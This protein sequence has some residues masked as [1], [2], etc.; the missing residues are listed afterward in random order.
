MRRHY[1]A[2]ADCVRA[3]LFHKH[4]KILSG[5]HQGFAQTDRE[6]CAARSPRRQTGGPWPGSA[7]AVAAYGR[8]HPSCHWPRLCAHGAPR[9]A[10]QYRRAPARQASQYHCSPSSPSCAQSAYRQMPHRAGR[11]PG[12]AWIKLPTHWFCQCHWPRA[13]PWRA[14][15]N[16]ASDFHAS[17]NGSAA[18]LQ[19]EAPRH[20]P[21]P[22]N[23]VVVRDWRKPP[24]LHPHRHENVKRLRVFIIAHQSGRAAIG[25]FKSCGFTIQLAGNIH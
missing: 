9:R 16:Q 15:R 17:G 25:Q 1:P 3:W 2:T 22:H 12:P 23:L 7:K 8:Y 19:Y 18:K 4:S 21:A 6:I 24:P 10:N 13:A 5:W 11:A 14:A 20:A